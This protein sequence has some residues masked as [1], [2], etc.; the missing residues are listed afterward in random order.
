MKKQEVGIPHIYYL[1]LHSKIWEMARGNSIKEKE[2][3]KYL[4]QWKIPEKIK[5]LIIKEL[6]ILGLLKKEKK[7]VLKIER[8]KFNEESLNEYYHKLGIF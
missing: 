5:I 4:F 6:I 3:K 2:L 8:P 1:Y 7:Y